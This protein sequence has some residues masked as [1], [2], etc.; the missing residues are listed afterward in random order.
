MNAIARTL[1]LHARIARTYPTA[2]LLVCATFALVLYYG[3][4]EHRIAHA[5]GYLF[6]VW[7][8]AFVTDLA[9]VLHPRV[10][11]GFPIRKPV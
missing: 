9:I 1:R 10:A 2:M 6:A 8:G 3:W 4:I 7:I 5:M 11:I